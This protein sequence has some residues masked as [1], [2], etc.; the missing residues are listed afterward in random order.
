MEGNQGH[1]QTAPTSWYYLGA[2]NQ[3][4]KGPLAASLAGRDF[5]GYQSETGEIA[6]LS[7]RCSHLGARLANGFV[8][9]DRLVCPLHGWEYGVDGI[10]KRIPAGDEIPAFARQ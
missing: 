7:G 6:V 3:L 2:A 1:F 10:C 5:V 9:G 8:K 4:A